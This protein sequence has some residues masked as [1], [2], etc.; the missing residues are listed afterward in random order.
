MRTKACFLFLLLAL[1]SMTLIGGV[2]PWND[3]R[4]CG[5]CGHDR[6]YHPGGGPCDL[7]V[8]QGGVLILGGPGHCPYFHK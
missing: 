4:V 6:S 5:Y 8:Y 7:A 3:H 1:V 2:H